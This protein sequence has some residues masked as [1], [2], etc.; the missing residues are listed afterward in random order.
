[1]TEPMAHVEDFCQLDVT[2]ISPR[3]RSLKPAI[4]RAGEIEYRVIQLRIRADLHSLCVECVEMA[5]ETRRGSK[6]ES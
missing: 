3:E 1:M 2:L 5:R 6:V 4:V